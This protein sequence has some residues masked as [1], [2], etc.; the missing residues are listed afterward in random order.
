MANTFNPTPIVETRATWCCIASST[1]EVSTDADL[2]MQVSIFKDQPQA[3]QK[4]VS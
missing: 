4:D 1:L 2:L 3:A